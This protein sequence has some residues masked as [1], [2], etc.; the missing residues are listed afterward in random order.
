LEKEIK[1]LALV[2]YFLGKG[3]DPNMQHGNN[4]NNKILFRD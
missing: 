2:V 1:D 3:G 4:S